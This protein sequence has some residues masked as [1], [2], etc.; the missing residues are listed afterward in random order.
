MTQ[1]PLI[2]YRRTSVL[3]VLVG[4]PIISGGTSDNGYPFLIS[5]SLPS[6][7]FSYSFFLLILSISL[8]IFDS[9]LPYSSVRLIPKLS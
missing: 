4:E 6:L 5:K 8:A 9:L 1:L 2:F 7:C 3:R